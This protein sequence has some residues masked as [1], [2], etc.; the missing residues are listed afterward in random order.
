[1]NK[2]FKLIIFGSILGL[3]V[4]FFSGNYIFKDHVFEII[5]EKSQIQEAANSKL[6]FE[7]TYFLIF[8]AAI[9]SAQ[10]I[11]EDESD[12]I[13]IDSAV[14]LNVVLNDNKEKLGCDLIGSGKIRYENQD[15]SFYLDDLNIDNLSIQ[16]IPEKYHQKVSAIAALLLKDHFARKPIYKLNQGSLKIQLARAVLKDVKIV[17]GKLYVYLGY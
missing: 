17:N 3:L 10:V 15:S 14:K 1:M 4:I 6:P 12:R 11:L 2:K 9:D 16:G 8:Q 13:G 5:I 7:K